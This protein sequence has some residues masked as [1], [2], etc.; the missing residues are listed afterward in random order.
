[1]QREIRHTYSPAFATSSV[2]ENG[3][4]TRQI[5]SDIALLAFWGAM[6][7]AFLWIGNAAGF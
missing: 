5:V 1:M 4:S 3:T 2:S 7:P 6:V